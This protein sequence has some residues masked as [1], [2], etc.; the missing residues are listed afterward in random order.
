MCRERGQHPSSIFAVVSGATGP[1][2]QPGRVGIGTALPIALLNISS[3]YTGSLFRIDVEE[4]ESVCGD[5]ICESD[6]DENSCPEDCLVEEEEEPFPWL[7]VV[8]PIIGLI[9]I[10]VLVVLVKKGVGGKKSSDPLVLFIQKAR[11]KGKKPQ[12]I[13]AS[14][15]R[16]G[17]SENKIYAAMRKAR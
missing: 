5:F 6:E 14:L 16:K 15:K 9:L 2:N 7:L 8:L 11:K 10:I 4:D 3:S 1:G 12:A 13:I 17:W